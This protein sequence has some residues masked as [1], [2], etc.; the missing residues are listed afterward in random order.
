[1]KIYIGLSFFLFSC[2]VTDKGEDSLKLN[3]YWV[4][5]S[6]DW[7]EGSFKILRIQDTAFYQLASTN[8]KDEKDSI[9]FMVEPGVN[10]SGGTVDLEGNRRSIR[11]QDLYKDIPLLSDQFPGVIKYDTLYIIRAD[12]LHLFYQGKKYVRTDMIKQKSI[13]EISNFINNFSR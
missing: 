8:A 7:A 1:M 11:F 3:G 12:T 10:L 4:P 13:V 5:D 9:H 6:I 2:V